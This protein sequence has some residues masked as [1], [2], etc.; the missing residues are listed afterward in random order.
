MC[1]PLRFRVFVVTRIVADELCTVDAAL[2]RR[3]VTST[4]TVDGVARVVHSLPAHLCL[5]DTRRV[6]GP[7]VTA[8]SRSGGPEEHFAVLPDKD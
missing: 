8:W 7:F 6:A 1:I 2:F 3:F 5:G 4:S